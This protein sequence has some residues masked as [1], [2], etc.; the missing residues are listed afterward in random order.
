MKTTKLTKLIEILGTTPSGDR[1]DELKAF[2]TINQTAKEI[3]QK[4]KCDL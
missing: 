1:N 4:T 3:Q 2:E